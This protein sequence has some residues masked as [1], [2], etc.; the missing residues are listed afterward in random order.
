MKN[1]TYLMIIIILAAALTT[2]CSVEPESETL[3]SYQ[4]AASGTQ[5]PISSVDPGYGAAGSFTNTDIALEQ[6]LIYAIQ[7][8]YLAR[9]EYEYIID[10][11]DGGTPFTN[12]IRSEESHISLLIPLFEAY[13]YDIPA[14]TS[15]SHLIIPV[16]ITEA[17]ET[18]VKAEIDNIAM[19]EK[20]LESNLPD[21]VA[22]VFIELRDAS[23]NHLDAFQRKLSR[24]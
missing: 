1:K 19:Y 22:A 18:G 6:M 12:I 16:S 11:L 17:L 23:K 2:A 8:E 7:D 10:E 21:D 13:G 20:F 5:E 24:S 14:D 15:A 9:S 4:P 3:L